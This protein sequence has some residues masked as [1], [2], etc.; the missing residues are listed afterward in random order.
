MELKWQEE[1]L[2]LETEIEVNVAKAKL[3]EEAVSELDEES[4][5][6][7]RLCGNSEDYAMTQRGELQTEKQEEGIKKCKEHTAKEGKMQQI[8]EER[9]RES[10]PK[11]YQGYAGSY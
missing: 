4:A 9:Q 5:Q 1:Q 6:D 8:P 7:W 11:D 3:I 2:D 10:Y